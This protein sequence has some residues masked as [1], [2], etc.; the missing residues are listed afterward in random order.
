MVAVQA[1]L[2]V[3]TGELEAG[4]RAMPTL[5]LIYALV[6]GFKRLKRARLEAAISHGT[7]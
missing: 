1:E 3:T 2:G 4:G 6:D 7:K 5:P